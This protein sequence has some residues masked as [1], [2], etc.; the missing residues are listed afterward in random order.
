MTTIL[1]HANFLLNEGYGVL[2]FDL[3]ESKIYAS[4]DE[5]LRDIEIID[6][7]KFQTY[8][9]DRK[10]KIDFYSIDDIKGYCKE[11]YPDFKFIY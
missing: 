1:E 4:I 2:I 8:S 9:I 6:N 7:G 11:N 10:F 3:K 5:N